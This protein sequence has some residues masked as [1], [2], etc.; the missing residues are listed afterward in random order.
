MSRSD[1]PRA[2]QLTT[3]QDDP[4][5]IGYDA[6]KRTDVEDEMDNG[7]RGGRRIGIIGGHWATETDGVNKDAVRQGEGPNEQEA[8]ADDHSESHETPREH[9]R[10]PPAYHHEPHP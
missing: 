6:Q 8:E 10:Q 9:A 5:R 1:V 7:V 3:E 4:D 2:K